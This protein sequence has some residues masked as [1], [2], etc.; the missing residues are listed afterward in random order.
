VQAALSLR[1]VWRTS[2][3]GDEGLYIWAGHVEW[4]HW[5]H[6]APMPDFASYFSGAPALYPP[7][8]AA[9]DTL[10]GLAG[11]RVL[12]TVFILAATCFLYGTAM[13]L[14]GRR[15]AVAGSALFA[16]CGAAQFL[17][18]FA[19]YDAMTICLL[20]CSTWIAVRAATRP[21]LA[22]RIGL[23]VACGIVLALADAAKYVGLL[24]DPV[25]VA[26]A[27]CRAWQARGSLRAGAVAGFTVASSL[28]AAVAAGLSAAPAGYLAGIAY[29]TLNRTQ[30]SF[31]AWQILIVAAGWSGLVVL[32]AVVGVAAV[33]C[34]WHDA[35][36]RLLGG[37]LAG[38][39]L[40]VPAAAAHAHLFTSMFKHVGYGEWFAAIPGGYALGA[41]T[42]TV[43]RPKFRAAAR[44]VLLIAGVAAFAGFSL[45]GN[46]YLNIG[47]QIGT[48]LPAVGRA[49]AG[50]KGASVASDDVNV[51]QYY[52]AGIDP[53]ARVYAIGPNPQWAIADP[54]VAVTY[55]KL[56]GDAA[57]AD[58]IA[59]GRFTVV[60]VSNF[61]LWAIPDAVA[62]R[63][64]AASGR[65][66][67]VAA[68]P[69]TCD[70][71]HAVYQAWV[72]R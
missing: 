50:V 19:T 61:H 54:A 39:A 29:T 58:A 64:L 70:G 63:A 5:V 8:A 44:M 15:A 52:V 60:I 18:A 23:L 7:L 20:A 4:A 65:Y 43:P 72:L 27:A 37:T 45:A 68:V 36:T 1:L 48:V 17:G 24:F 26:V 34:A 16:G 11:A 21:T 38:A 3:Y 42:A 9:A 55:G 47:P 30:G 28:G 25:V 46:Q 56:G 32:L 66:R 33:S 6:G 51:A 71:Q 14:F 12:S 22:V 59:H 10:G 13:R 57:L 35:P 69:Y 31:P 2:A 53:S 67:L 40:L 41:F 62:G 49:L